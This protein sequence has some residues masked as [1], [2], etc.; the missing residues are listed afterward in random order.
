MLISA[1]WYW[2]AKITTPGQSGGLEKCL[3]ENGAHTGNAVA[4]AVNP[5]RSANRKFFVTSNGRLGLGPRSCAAE[6]IVCI[7]FGCKAPLV[8]RRDGGAM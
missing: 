3:F 6:D 1:H 4:G 8:S 5:Q 2:S 7:I